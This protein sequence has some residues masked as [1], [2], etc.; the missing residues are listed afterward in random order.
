M[1]TVVAIHTTFALVD[2]LKP[3]YLE[4]LPGIRVVNLVDDSLLADVRAAGGPTPAVT[5]RILGYGTLAASSGASAIFSCCS[6]VGEVADLLAR[7]VEIPVVKIDDRMASRAVSLGTRIGIVATVP[8]TL[9]PTE[10]LIRRKASEAGTQ[11]DIG[12]YLVDGAF[13][14]LTSGDA[15]A[16]DRLVLEGIARAASECDVVALAQGSMAR[17]APALPRSIAVPILSSP[18]LGVEALRAALGLE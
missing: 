13:D 17:L 15:A 12:R 3:L 11:V 2:P 16:H 6:S 5:R 1:T 9:N 8:T 18:R 7:A 10:Q 14:A 4:L